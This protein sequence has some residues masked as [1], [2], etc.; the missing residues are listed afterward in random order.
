VGIIIYQLT[1]HTRSPDDGEA[2]AKALLVR[3]KGKEKQGRHF[4]GR[5]FSFLLKPFL[6]CQRN[7]G[8]VFFTFRFKK[9]AS[10]SIEEGFL[11]G[12]I[13]NVKGDTLCFSACAQHTR[14]FRLK[15]SLV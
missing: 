10:L 5:R 15:A 6:L 14:N 1:L 3:N 13:K 12:L 4:L 11:F 9:A 8:R 2:S 7:K